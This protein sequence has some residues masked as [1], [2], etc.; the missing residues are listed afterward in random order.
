MGYNIR[1]IIHLLWIGQNVTTMVQ[2]QLFH[3]L[4]NAET[5]KWDI[6]FILAMNGCA[7]SCCPF[8]ITWGDP[9]LP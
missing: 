8:S 2:T 7:T 4:F 3:I 9:V 5:A 1:Y 6:L